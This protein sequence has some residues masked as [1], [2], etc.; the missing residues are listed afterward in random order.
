MLK[1]GEHLRCLRLKNG[2]T[3]ERLA[4][5]LGVSPQAVS[6][7]ETGATYPDI[8]LLPTIA[9][10]F[11]ATLDELFGMDEL[12][13]EDM[14][15]KIFTM[16]HDLRREGKTDEAI[17]LLKDAAKACPNNYALLSELSLALSPSDADEAIALAEK[18]M[19]NSANEKV[20]GTTRANLCFL[21]LGAGMPEKALSLGKTLPHI[22]ESREALLPFIASACGDVAADELV[23]SSVYS[24]LAL[25]C[26]LIRG[27]L[28]T[29]E[30]FALGGPDPSDGRAMLEEI[31]AY[32]G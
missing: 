20:R 4:E 24:A 15:R 25:A 1:F 14:A 7:W 9:N 3:Q 17:A 32:I 19:Q 13:G 22:R 6:R 26:R 31:G 28:P 21:Y 16:A 11:E 12:R 27:T 5:L 29:A 8:T 10:C 2:P 30:D 18:V 23:R